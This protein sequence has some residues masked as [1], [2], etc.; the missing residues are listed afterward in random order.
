MKKFSLLFVLLAMSSVCLAADVVK[1]DV[2]EASCKATGESCKTF[3]DCCGLSVCER[4]W[5]FWV[6]YVCKSAA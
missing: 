5:I 3:E 4:E 6:D 2:A 1:A